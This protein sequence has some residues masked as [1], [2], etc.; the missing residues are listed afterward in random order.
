MHI[1]LKLK[2]CTRMEMKKYSMS[3]SFNILIFMFL[4]LLLWSFCLLHTSEGKLEVNQGTLTEQTTCTSIQLWPHKD[5]LW[6]LSARIQLVVH[7]VVII[8]HTHWLVH[9]RGTNELYLRFD[10]C[11][12]ISVNAHSFLQKVQ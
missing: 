8:G 1:K 9:V 12:N 3:E 5:A 2:H 4:L 7:E 10:F 11:N 6:A